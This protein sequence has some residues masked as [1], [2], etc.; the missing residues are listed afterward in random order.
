MTASTEAP[1][2][3]SESCSVFIRSDHVYAAWN[4][5]LWADLLYLTE[6]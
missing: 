3:R 5:G 4:L 6:S 1:S 2:R